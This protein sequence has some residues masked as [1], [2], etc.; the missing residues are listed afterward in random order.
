MIKARLDPRASKDSKDCKVSRVCKDPW[1]LKECKD[2]WGLKERRRPWR[3][4]QDLWDRLDPKA[5]GAFQ[6][7][8]DLG[9]LYRGRK[10]SE[11]FRVRP[12]PIQPRG[13]LMADIPRVPIRAKRCLISDA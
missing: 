8:W 3:D 12:E 11:G 9:R 5:S 4:P 7:P 10:A 1:G 13:S 6:D 2:P